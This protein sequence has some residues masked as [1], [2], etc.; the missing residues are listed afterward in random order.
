MAE[1]TGFP[2]HKDLYNFGVVPSLQTLRLNSWGQEAS[3][4]ELCEDIIGVTW[5]H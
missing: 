4:T 3:I 1:T 5:K 2:S